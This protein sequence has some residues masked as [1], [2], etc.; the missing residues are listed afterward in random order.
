MPFGCASCLALNEIWKLHLLTRYR[1]WLLPLKYLKCL[2]CLEQLTKSITNHIIHYS[3]CKIVFCFQNS[4]TE[5]YQYTSKAAV[6]KLLFWVLWHVKLLMCCR[7][8]DLGVSNCDKMTDRGLVEGI[9]PLY[10]LTS[11]RLVG[12]EKLS[13]ETLSTFLRRSSMAS[14]L[15]LDLSLCFNLDDEGLKGIAERCSKLIYLHV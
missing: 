9:G 13:A 2:V 1:M 6:I 4:S 15:L 11:L 12:G 3:G 7:L 10:E 5:H 8:Q 14:I